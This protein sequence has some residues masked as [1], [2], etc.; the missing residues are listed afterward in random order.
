MK[1]LRV[2]DLCPEA[3]RPGERVGETD[4]ERANRLELQVTKLSLRL[5]ETAMERDAAIW[6]LHDM[7]RKQRPVSGQAPIEP[8]SRQAV[9]LL[10]AIRAHQIQ[11]AR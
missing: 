10:N 2:E 8:P 11:G 6:H 4:A 5:L 3:K 1:R 7:L 9:A